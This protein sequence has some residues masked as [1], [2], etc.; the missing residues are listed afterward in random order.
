[1]NLIFDPS[2]ETRFPAAFVESE[3]QRLILHEFG[4][5]LGLI[6]EH[7]RPR[8]PIQWDKSAL[9]AYALRSWGW[10]KKTVDEQILATYRSADLSGT[11]FDTHSI[12]MYQYPR[13][14]AYYQKVDPVGMPLLGPD[15]QALPD[16]TE[17]FESPNNTRLTPMDKVAA[18]IAYPQPADPIEVVDLDVGG[19][20]I[21]SSIEAKEQVARFRFETGAPGRYTL[22]TK[23]ETPT[24]LALLRELRD[25]SDRGKSG[26][27]LAAAESPN[28]HTGSSMTQALPAKTQ[29][30]VEVRH[31][32]PR[33]GVGQFSIALRQGP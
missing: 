31:W 29:Y 4:H 3:F 11:E 5:A 18:A 13:G 8:R 32:K 22:D 33:T 23:G 25:P 2:L 26:N 12:M 14:L 30:H 28:D 27:I 9:Y 16:Y 15:G 19:A 7:Q 10:D 17:P 6:H 1:M 21:R 24:L 20:P